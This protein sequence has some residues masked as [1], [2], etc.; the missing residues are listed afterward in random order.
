MCALQQ[1]LLVQIYDLWATW[2]NYTSVEVQIVFAGAA[3]APAVQGEIQKEW[4]FS[5]Q[6]DFN[7]FTGRK[8]HFANANWVQ[9][10]AKK[11]HYENHL[12]RMYQNVFFEQ[13]L[14]TGLKKNPLW[15][16]AGGE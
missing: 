6:R 14:Y 9:W 8:A 7:D 3:A 12:I 13:G 15:I 2:F 4:P 16:S 10:L 1:L 5:P 11:K